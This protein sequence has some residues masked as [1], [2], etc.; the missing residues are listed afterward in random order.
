MKRLKIACENTKKLL[1]IS[2]E[3]N[4]CV[5]GIIENVDIIEII[6]RKEFEM[7]CQ[8]LFDKLFFPI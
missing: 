7:K 5:N 3:A 2:E 8:L 6:E 1:I 4:I